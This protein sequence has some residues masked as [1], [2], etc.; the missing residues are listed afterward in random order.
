MSSD[1]IAL[2]RMTT[3]QYDCVEG[4]IRLLQYPPL[5]DRVGYDVGK[6]HRTRDDDPD[7]RSMRQDCLV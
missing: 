5:I 6:R 3:N 7:G 2:I 1:V 4:Y